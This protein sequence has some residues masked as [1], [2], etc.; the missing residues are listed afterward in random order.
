MYQVKN[1]ETGEIKDFE[2]AIDAVRYQEHLVF[3][4]GI[5]AEIL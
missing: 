1:N 3:V 5:D 4:L 2:R